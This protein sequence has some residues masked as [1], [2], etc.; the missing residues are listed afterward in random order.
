MSN[1][2]FLRM[3]CNARR[4]QLGKED[5]PPLEF[6]AFLAP[7][8]G[9]CSAGM[10]G[11]CTTRA[12]ALKL[13]RE[14]CA[15]RLC[16]LAAGGSQHAYQLPR[17]QRQC[18]LQRERPRLMHTSTCSCVGDLSCVRALC[19]CWLGR[20]AYAAS[21]AACRLPNSCQ[22]VPEVQGGEK[23]RNEI[24]QLAVLEVRPAPVWPC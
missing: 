4:K 17:A 10:S 22:T 3:A 21:L 11:S 8:V 15:L 9:R 2:D 16:A 19:C 24:L 13:Q 1:I 6:Y 20:P 5:L 23:K 18:R 7:K 14:T 12:Q